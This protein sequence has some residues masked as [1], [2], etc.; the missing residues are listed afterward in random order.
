MN[1]VTSLPLSGLRVITLEQAVAAPFC[2]RQLADMGADVIK[3]ERP[4]G[5]DF[6]RDYDHVIN[7]QSAYFVWLNRGKRSVVLDLKQPEDHGKFNQL[8]MRADIF[9]HNLAPGAV[10]RL[11]FDYETLKEKH[12]RLI[13]C[14]ISGYGPDGP[15]RDKRAYDMLIQAES[16]VP[17][18]TG[19]PDEPAKVGVSIADIAAGLYGYS[20]ILAALLNR[21][22][23]GRGERIEISMFECLV[24]W[25]MPPIYVWEG[26]GCAPV[27][28]GMRHNMIVPYGAYPC[29]DDLVNF[30]IQNEREWQRFCTTVLQL[31]KL[32][33]D[34]RF[35]S[36]AQRLQN[37]QELESLIENTFLALSK[38]EV[39][40]RLEIAKIANGALNDVAKVAT[41]T[42]LEARKRWVEVNSPQGMI[43]TLLPPHNLS[44][45][46]PYMGAIPALGEHTQEV[47]NELQEKP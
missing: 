41:H 5:G 44:S 46:V 20:S 33:Q 29:K 47:L 8:L 9:I 19:S 18:L 31:P 32:A 11:G 2:S 36:N 13:W 21:E 38:Q 26:S 34:K 27:R 15:Y 30:A 7:G 42:Q 40:T 43:K 16:G 25:M 3:I 22:R 12:P 6:S 24:E 23:S 17:S 14:A 10:E 35:A 1:P 39:I 45:I 28:A 4:D 37:R